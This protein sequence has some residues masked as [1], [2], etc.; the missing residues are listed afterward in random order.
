MEHAAISRTAFYR[1]FTDV[2]NVVAEILKR[3]TE[4]LVS[5]S[6]PWLDEPGAFGSPATISAALLSFARAFHDDGVLLGA[7]ADASRTDECLHQLW[8]GGLVEEF[9]TV[10]TRAIARDQAAGLVR[11]DLNPEKTALGLNLM[12]EAVAVEVLGRLGGGTP[13]DFVSIVAPIW[14]HTL[15]EQDV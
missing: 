11:P 14:V 1:Q 12:D 9:N 3:A 8:R 15:F 7:L 10:V 5:R 2:H 4:E 6:G 13:A